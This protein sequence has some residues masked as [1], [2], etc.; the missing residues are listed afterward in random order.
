MSWSL[1]DCYHEIENASIRMLE[2][3]RSGDWEQ[4]SELEAVCEG[5]ISLIQ[6]FG[7]E[8]SMD[9]AQRAEK[10]RVMQQILRM[11]AEVRTLLN[12]LVHDFSVSL[13]STG[14]TLH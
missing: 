10:A 13:D 4:V 14:H 3:A 5:L 7:P 9:A 11:D 2:A 6:R 1:M 8:H 12:P